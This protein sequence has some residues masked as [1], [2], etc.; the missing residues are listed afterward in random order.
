MKN[1][2]P[3]RNKFSIIKDGSR[4]YIKCDDT[5]E[6]VSNGISTLWSAKKILKEHVK[7]SD[8]V[9]ASKNM[10]KEEVEQRVKIF[11]GRLRPKKKPWTIQEAILVASIYSSRGELYNKNQALYTSAYCK[12]WLNDICAHMKPSRKKNK[13]TY[14][15]LNPNTAMA[16]IFDSNSHY[17]FAKQNPG[18]Y[19][20]MRRF[21]IDTIE[22]FEN[23]N[24]AAYLQSVIKKL[25]E[26]SAERFVG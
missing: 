20:A 1:G 6:L 14:G 12:G 10:T 18:A 3:S 15:V 23:R 21:G 9:E 22:L 11:G 24:D 16:K 5:L 17:D 26:E 13:Y 8:F 2:Y 7:T 4:Y 19:E 25:A